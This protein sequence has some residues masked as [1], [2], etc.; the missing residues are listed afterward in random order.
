MPKCP[1]RRWSPRARTPRLRARGAPTGSPGAPARR[2][3]RRSAVAASSARAL[4]NTDIA[5]EVLLRTVS[6]SSA[7][8]C[9]ISTNPNIPV[10]RL[11]KSWAMPPAS[12]PRA[13]SFWVFRTWSS[14]RSRS[15]TSRNTNTAPMM[16]LCGSRMG[17]AL[18]ATSISRPSR[19]HEEAGRVAADDGPVRST[20]R[21]G[22]PS[23]RRVCRSM[24]RKTRSAGWPAASADV[25]PVR[26]SATRFISI[27]RPS[28]S[29][30]MTP[31]PMLRSVT[32][33]RSFSDTSSLLARRE[34]R[35]AL[36][37]AVLEA[38]P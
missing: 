24:V 31:S 35:R 27:T 36:V 7:P 34:L 9:A 25:Q 21:A 5:R 16:R 15:V 2:P 37:D 12:T 18:S 32:A 11:L 10:S 26:V 1:P 23:G 19:A 20:W 4:S 6:A 17:A 8:S 13:S 29:V 28:T 14:R 22:S 38:Q 3:S 30:A 33:R